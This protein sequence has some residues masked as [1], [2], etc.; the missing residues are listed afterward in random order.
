MPKRLSVGGREEEEEELPWRSSHLIPDITSLSERSL[1]T[2]P[3]Q[4]RDDPSS[5]LEG[6]EE[7]EEITADKPT[8]KPTHKHN[9]D[10]V[11]ACIL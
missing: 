4:V 5:T 11:P 9:S 8:N 3:T 10:S 1:G 2:A 7:D 6:L